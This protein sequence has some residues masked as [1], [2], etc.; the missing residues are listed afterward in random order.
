MFGLFKRDSEMDVLQKKHAKAMKN[1]HRLS[2]IDR[3]ASDEFYAEAEAIGQQ[4]D[5]LKNKNK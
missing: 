2:S 1:W 3:K 5:T 4:I